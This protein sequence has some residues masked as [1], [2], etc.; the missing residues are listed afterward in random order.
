MPAAGCCDATDR[1][2]GPELARLDL[3]RYRRRGPTGTARRLLRMLE[4]AGAG[5]DTHLDIGAGIGV[6]HHEL[7]RGRVRTAVHVEVSRAYLDAARDEAARRGHQARVRFLHGDFLTH[8]P[9]LEPADLVTLD[10]V[11]CCYPDL[12]AIVEASAAKARRYWAASFPRERWYVRAHTRWENFRRRR[13]GNSFRT[14]VHPVPAIHALLRRA[15]LEEVA[16]GRSPVW[17][18]ALYARHRAA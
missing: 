14:F 6:L 2:F 4:R 13:A 5:G 18:V 16:V 10:R 3:A 1:H 9:G 8:A 12:E 17:E 15:G 11:V 7:L